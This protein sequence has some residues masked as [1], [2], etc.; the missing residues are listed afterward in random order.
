MYCFFFF[1]SFK[2]AKLSEF[3]NINIHKQE[4]EQL[5]F[6]KGKSITWNKRRKTSIL[7]YSFRTTDFRTSP[8][9]YYIILLPRA[10]LWEDRPFI[11]GQVMNARQRIW[12]V[13][14]NR[15]G[16]PMREQWQCITADAQNLPLAHSQADFLS[17]YINYYLSMSSMN[18]QNT[19]MHTIRV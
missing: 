2:R 3:T 14:K 17:N 5:G 6:H 12:K 1:F 11:K 8:P 18:Y 15:P 10:K 16:L 19:F 7:H 9:V 13:P 4:M